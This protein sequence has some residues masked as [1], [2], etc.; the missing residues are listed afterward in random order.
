MIR[1][2]RG[3]RLA[4]YAL[5]I[6]VVL[7]AR[8]GAQISSTQRDGR[9]PAGFSVLDSTFWEGPWVF[10][11]SGTARDALPRLYGSSGEFTKESIPIRLDDGS[12]GKVRVE[13]GPCTGADCG[14]EDCG[15]FCP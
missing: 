5:T 2:R 4:V 8:A 7:S 10:R 1:P 15:C 3:R 6:V 12:T 11:Q 14:P 9:V 13:A